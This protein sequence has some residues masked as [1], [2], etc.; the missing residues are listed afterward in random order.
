MTDSSTPRRPSS[1]GSD[2]SVDSQ[3][4]TV[5]LKRVGLS[6]EFATTKSGTSY[7]R[8]LNPDGTKTAWKKVEAP[9]D[10]TQPDSRTKQL[11]LVRHNQAEGEP[12]HWSLETADVEG[13]DLEGNVYQVSGD[14][15]FM[16]YRPNQDGVPVPTLSNPDIRDYFVLVPKL[17]PELEDIVKEV[18]AAEPPPQAK[19]RKEVK[20]N[21]QYWAIRVM[22]KLVELGMMDSQK[23]VDCQKLL[24][25]LRK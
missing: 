5:S 1:A 15:E 12:F 21:C 18:A 11:Y 25:P 10:N 16:D 9:P 19:S 7:V 4:P 3:D 24:E 2:L 14:A 8:T 22:K 13:G 20:E 6:K 23:V 17:T